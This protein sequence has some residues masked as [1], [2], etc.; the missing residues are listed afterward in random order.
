[1]GKAFKF[2]QPVLEQTGLYRDTATVSSLVLSGGGWGAGGFVSPL[3]T[4]DLGL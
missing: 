4:V 1:M 2:V 3:T